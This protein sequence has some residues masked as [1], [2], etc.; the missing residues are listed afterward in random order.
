MSTA[1]RRELRWSRI[2]V[3]LIQAGIVSSEIWGDADTQLEAI[4]R[5]DTQD[6]YSEPME[7]LY[8]CLQSSLRLAV[9]PTVIATTIKK[10]LEARRPRSVYRSGPGAYLA[11]IGGLLPDA[12]LHRL[13]ER[14]AARDR[15]PAHQKA[16]GS[17][18]G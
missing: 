16:T 14:F 5:E 11:V 13:L 6:R 12:L 9:P 7:A 18:R 15:G 2:P 3:S 4:R 8:H 17:G 10:A 1:L